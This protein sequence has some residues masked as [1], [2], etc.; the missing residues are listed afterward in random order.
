MEV[1]KT[2][3]PGAQAERLRESVHRILAHTARTLLLAWEREHVSK[4]VDQ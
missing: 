3:D 1:R 4:G 2:A